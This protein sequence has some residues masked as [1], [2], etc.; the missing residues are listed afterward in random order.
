MFSAV[1]GTVMR[2]CLNALP[3]GTLY[4]SPTASLC[5]RSVLGKVD[6]LRKSIQETGK[7]AA[8]RASSA[9]NKQVRKRALVVCWGGQGIVLA[10]RSLF[11]L[12]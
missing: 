9:P 2:M 12:I 10:C 3:D 1:L 11:R 4:V 6:G 8:K 5:H 7:A